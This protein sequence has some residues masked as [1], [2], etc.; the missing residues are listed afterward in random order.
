MASIYDI[1]LN[2][3]AQD[4][5]LGKQFKELSV[6]F[7]QINKKAAGVGDSLKKA[8]A[9]GGS[10]KRF[11]AMADQMRQ[12]NATSQ[13]IVKTFADMQKK[14]QALT[15]L[16]QQELQYNKQLVTD[17]RTLAGVYQRIANLRSQ[18]NIFNEAQIQ[19]ARRL[20][21]LEAQKLQ[22]VSAE[23]S[24][25]RGEAG[26]ERQRQ[27]AAV[28]L[29]IAEAGLREPLLQQLAIKQRLLTLQSQLAVAKSPEVQQS[30]I[31]VA[32]AQKV[33]QQAIQTSIAMQTLSG[34]IMM[35][36]KQMAPFAV[37]AGAVFI[38]LK[39]VGSMAI[40]TGKAVGSTLVRSLQMMVR[41]SM[42]AVGVMGRLAASG[43]RVIG[44]IGSMVA[45]FGSAIRTKQRYREMTGQVA[46]AE[47]WHSRSLRGLVGNVVNVNRWINTLGASVRQLGQALQNAGTT[48]SIFL[49]LPVSMF[50]R[51][52]FDT[53]VKFDEQII[54]IRKNAGMTLEE[55]RALGDE[56]RDLASRSPTKITDLGAIAVDA[57]KLGLP[58]KYIKEFVETMDQF[59]VSTDITAD[60][61]TEQVGKILNI[62]YD[63]GAGLGDSEEEVAAF[64]HTLRGLASAINEIGQANAVG[65]QD[66]I[67]ALL[68]MAP[69]AKALEM[70]LADAVGLAGSLASASASPERAGTQLAQALTKIAVDIDKFADSSGMLVEQVRMFVDTD[71]ASAFVAI[72]EAIAKIE[73]PTERAAAAQEL[74]G[75][76]GGKAANTVSAAL[77]TTINNIALSRV[78]FEEAVSISREFE[79]AMDSV[80]NQ[81]GL[82]RNQFDLIGLSL[83][84]ALLP[85]ITDVLSYLVP[86]MQAVAKSF[87]LLD[88]KT[89][90]L[91]VSVL[92]GVAVF[93][94]LL[95][96]LGSL[97]FSVGILTTGLTGLFT[98]FMKIF[99]LPVK[100]GLAILAF[101]SPIKLLIGGLAIA[102]A[103]MLGFSGVISNLAEMVVSFGQ[104]M[105]KWGYNAFM[106]FGEGI[107]AAGMYVVDVVVAIL[108][109]IRAMLEAFSPP[110]AGP[111]KNID[112]WGENIAQTFIDGFARASMAPVH[113]F[114]GMIASVLE[115]T[116]Y[117]LGER[118]IGLYSDISGVV[119]SIISDLGSFAG[120]DQEVLQQNTIGG[121]TAF[122]NVID[123]IE[124]GTIGLE[125]AFANLATY[126]GG[127]SVD[128]QHLILLQ[129]EYNQGQE[130]L[131]EIQEELDNHDKAVNDEVKA[132]AARKD[133]SVR[134]RIAMIRQARVAGALRKIQLQDEQ[135]AAEQQQENIQTQIELQRE[136]IDIFR[137]LLPSAIQSASSAASDLADST[138][139]IDD[140]P[141][142][143]TDFQGMAD[144]IDAAGD[145]IKEKLDAVGEDFGRFAKSVSAA[146]EQLKG[147]LDA[148]L[149]RE[150]VEGTDNPDYN[151][152]YDKGWEV[153]ERYLAWLTD[154]NT[155]WGKLKDT[156]EFLA[157]ALGT[158]YAAFNLVMNDEKTDAKKLAEYYKTLDSWYLTFVK[159]GTELGNIAKKLRE[160]GQAAGDVFR[161][162]LGA[163]EGESTLDAVI[164]K[165]N[166]FTTAFKNAF[167]E[168]NPLFKNPLLILAPLGSM[169]YLLSVIAGLVFDNLGVVGEVLGVIANYSVRLLGVAGALAVIAAS[170]AGMNDS[171]LTKLLQDNLDLIGSGKLTEV[172]QDAL[173]LGDPNDPIG[174]QIVDYIY[175]QITETDWSSIA[176]G[177]AQSINDALFGNTTYSMSFAGPAGT[178]EQG[179]GLLDLVDVSAISGVLSSVVGAVVEFVASLE[180]GQFGV[181]IAGE[182]NK[183][184]SD[185]S[186]ADISPA[187]KNILMAIADTLDTVEFSEIR[188]IIVNLLNALI[189][190]FK[191]GIESQAFDNAMKDFVGQ[192]I[193]GVAD[194]R[195]GD[196]VA[197]LGAFVGSFLGAVADAPWGSLSDALRD[198]LDALLK[199]LAKPS[200]WGSL[201]EVITAIAF[202]IADAIAHADWGQLLNANTL[203][204]VAKAI[205][206]GIARAI[207]KQAPWLAWMMGIETPTGTVSYAS[208]GDGVPTQ[209]EVDAINES[210][211]NITLPTYEPQVPQYT[212][213]AVAPDLTNLANQS[214]PDRFMNSLT[215]YYSGLSSAWGFLGEASGAIGN[216]FMSSW[217]D[218]SSTWDQIAQPSSDFLGGVGND[219]MSSWQGANDF[220][221]GIGQG[222]QDFFSGTGPAADAVSAW[223]GSTSSTASAQGLEE[224]MI[225]L[226]QF[227]ASGEQVYSAAQQLQPMATA[228]TYQEWI[229]AQNDMSSAVGTQT[230][231]YLSFLPMVGNATTLTGNA[232]SGLLSVGQGLQQLST[233]SQSYSDQLDPVL[234]M[235]SALQAGAGGSGDSF[236]SAIGSLIGQGIF[237]SIS[238]FALEQGGGFLDAIRLSL[239]AWIA[240]NLENLKIQGG[241]IALTVIG[242]FNSF[243]TE[244]YSKL[245][246]ILTALYTWIYNNSGSLEDGGRD[247]AQYI[248]DAAREDLS[249]PENFDII[250]KSFKNYVDGVTGDTSFMRKA[251][252]LGRSISSAIG[253]GV[254]A[255]WEDI[256]DSIENAVQ[257]AIDAVDVSVEPPAEPPGGKSGRSSDSGMTLVININAPIYGADANKFAEEVY[258]SISAKMAKDMRNSRRY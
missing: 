241:S 87:G 163:G 43:G 133:L 33:Q 255:N 223:L 149:G 89:K 186:T 105:Y 29:R 205:A 168:N 28:A 20:Q 7:E 232:T 252:S 50:G 22:A 130:R 5:G 170:L 101:L 73:S 51:G 242:G 236:S 253:D 185:L 13:A 239:F 179:T 61:A 92:L 85:A 112:V 128:L 141:E 45:S 193:Q 243:F 257:N 6:Q 196:L 103:A 173:A 32:Q 206:D 224:G 118:A 102:A 113:R 83:G 248:I 140:L 164:R 82:L 162:L 144:Q 201:A 165:L 27:D 12:M 41:A 25:K 54:E 94:P 93:G 126:T 21:T 98:V 219:F 111:L 216:D 211:S 36:A 209:A 47:G 97:M 222:F 225:G 254:E 69:A 116:V 23:I 19:L 199:E 180:L 76:I 30:M 159:L 40:S 84:D 71:P 64:S 37:A 106:G 99:A 152:G 183:I 18:S 246:S 17:T 228:M 55:A 214:D 59:V 157:A 231:G 31:Q 137:D 167:G 256:R 203:V 107:E 156:G 240:Q 194:V 15:Q 10:S 245:S 66:V 204:E 95:V 62:F 218:F 53:A 174:K 132:I 215:Q 200:L 182:F 192:F 3:R 176:R 81:M 108:T 226:Q 131:K 151:L 237:E 127:F 42:A 197:T 46:D 251:R 190:G 178:V 230:S 125:Q 115:D 169:A 198:L 188:E 171:N 177:L 49:S 161:V 160:Y 202:A 38:S 189:A 138:S 139:E 158:L 234:P 136:L 220:F 77:G 34:R 79:R 229:D 2:I 143:D 109:S 14:G 11:Q 191:S 90:M 63:L 24:L 65:E 91:I 88:Q 78:A 4:N 9:D 155:Q 172:I 145:Q 39:R 212:S 58:R 221:G 154:V 100:A 26:I 75:T 166:E 60:Q 142:L 122:I 217:N 238:S 233:V 117:G 1:L 120:L 213:Q 70:S 52:L 247:I 146:R 147:F 129:D 208:G 86:L 80:S 96:A 68:R 124:N 258:K 16:Q 244:N 181:K 134:E 121:L 210:L 250:E 187:V 119:T 56:I 74:F 57:A 44:S 67:D 72:A 150:R 8:M 235:L 148:L 35:A 249:R 135:A 123:A 195:W 48:F 110:K 153:R 227:T 175:K 104:N 114:T 207:Q 184:T